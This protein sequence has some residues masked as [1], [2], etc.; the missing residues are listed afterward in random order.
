MGSCLCVCICSAC[1][2]VCVHARAHVQNPNSK[3]RPRW[4][5]NQPTSTGV[6][7]I[8]S[9]HAKVHANTRLGTP[10]EVEQLLAVKV[11]AFTVLKTT[12]ISVGLCREHYNALYRE[13]HPKQL[14]GSCGALPGSGES[15]FS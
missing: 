13:L 7:N 1:V 5:Q 15:T 3:A 11:E 2:R 8:T 12:S 4:L 14:C 10:S 6:Y 9:C